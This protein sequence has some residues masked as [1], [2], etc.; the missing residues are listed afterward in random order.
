MLDERLIRREVVFEGRYLKTEV[1]TVMLPDG[2][3]STREVVSPPNA[4][5]ILPIDATGN[6]HLVRQYRT[7]LEKTIL[8]IPAGIFEPGE[9]PEATG[10]REC[11]EEV[12]MI[13]GR[14]ERLCGY[15]HSVGFSTGR[16]EIY[17]ATE[18]K[19]SSL[20]HN[21]HGEFLEKVILPYEQLLQMTLSGEIVD[22]KT[23]VAVLWYRQRSG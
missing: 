19:P 12:G 7:A 1:R 13:P 2:R 9:R 4:V 6:V 20:V 8:E 15:Y 23:I 14:M 16:I 18:L 10:R 3:S 22:S 11:E 5:G 17:L 21:E